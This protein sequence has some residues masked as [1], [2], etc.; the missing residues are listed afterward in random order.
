[1]MTIPAETGNGTP[2]MCFLFVFPPKT[3]TKKSLSN[4]NR[5][6]KS[7]RMQLSFNTFN[8]ILTAK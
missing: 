2:D 1:M 8:L 4:R 7:R 5:Q 3:K 6:L